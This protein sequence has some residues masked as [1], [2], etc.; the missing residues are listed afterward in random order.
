MRTAARDRKFLKAN[1][2]NI[3]FTRALFST[4]FLKY[5]REED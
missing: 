4:V 5:F 2:K 1:M 3:N